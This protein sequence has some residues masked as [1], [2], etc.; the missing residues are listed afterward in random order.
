MEKG[1]FITLY[2]INNMGKTTH[3]KLLVKRLNELGYKAVYMKYPV[4]DIEP[5][6]PIINAALR[7]EKQTMGEDQFQMW[8][9]INRYQYEDRLKELLAEGNIVIA[10]DYTGTGIAWGITKGLEEDW[11]ETINEKL[12]KE[13][14]AIMIE[15][16][17]STGAKEAVHIHEQN[18][19]LIAKSKKVHE[20]LAQKYGWQRVTLQPEIKDTS[21]LLFDVVLDYLEH[22]KL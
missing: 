3:S 21:D 2:G 8:Y 16:K 14:L 6:G 11:V 13:D 15:G 17:R 5:S 22:S 19:E 7:S 12:L 20:H 10:E 4:Y 18:D 9:A 1:K